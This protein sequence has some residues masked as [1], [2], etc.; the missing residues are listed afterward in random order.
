[1]E[2]YPLSKLQQILIEWQYERRH[3]HETKTYELKHQ[4]NGNCEITLKNRIT[5]I[6]IGGSFKVEIAPAVFRT[7]S[8]ALESLIDETE[9]DIFKNFLRE[10]DSEM[11]IM[12]EQSEKDTSHQARF[13]EK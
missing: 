4:A 5:I 3:S 9:M 10:F 1:M 11:Y 13:F 2:K 6:N 8:L 7:T 12:A